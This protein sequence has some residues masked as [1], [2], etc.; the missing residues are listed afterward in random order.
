MFLGPWGSS[1]SDPHYL[2]LLWRLVHTSSCWANEP[3]R[4]VCVLSNYREIL[5]IFPRVRITSLFVRTA[6]VL[7][8]YCEVLFTPCLVRL[9]IPLVRTICVLVNYCEV[10]FTPRL[11]RLTIPLVRTICV[12]VNYC[13]VL[14]TPCLVRIIWQSSG[15]YLHEWMNDLRVLRSLICHCRSLR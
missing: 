1:I 9:T 11:V 2:P 3:S 7:I 8:N 15:S 14:F 6:C 12:L 4:I 5:S 10:L 13:E